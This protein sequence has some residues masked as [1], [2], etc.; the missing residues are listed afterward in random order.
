V[1]IL[2][3]I[4]DSDQM[5]YVAA[6]TLGAAGTL[7]AAAALG[8]TMGI[9]WLG[10][11]RAKRAALRAFLASP[12]QPDDTATNAAARLAADLGP[13]E[14]NFPLP[15]VVAHGA[16]AAVTVTLVALAAFGAGSLSRA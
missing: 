14:R 7:G 4:Y 13:P 10:V 12:G 1:W 3:L 8:L 6:A 16:F 5:A 9:R 11:C 15:V 2:Y